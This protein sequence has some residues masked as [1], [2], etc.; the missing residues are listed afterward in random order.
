MTAC[1]VCK[2]LQHQFKNYDA[3]TP[4]AS[5]RERLRR[6]LRGLLRALPA[7]T[8]L[9]GT[10]AGQAGSPFGG[11]VRVC[12]ECGHAVMETPPD[13]AGLKRYYGRQYWS[14]RPT[15]D[16]HGAQRGQTRATAQVE[17][18]RECRRLAGQPDLPSETLEIGAA[19]AGATLRFKE[20][21]G[22]SVRTSVC[23]PGEHW[24]GHYAQHNIERLAE[25]YPFEA[26][27]QFDHIHSSHWLEHVLDLESTR[28]ALASQLKPGG[29]LFM[30]VPNCGAP[31]WELNLSDNPH[32]HFFTAASL[33]RAF[34]DLGLSCLHC[35]EY[36]MSLQERAAGVRPAAEQHAANPGGIW[37]RAVFLNPA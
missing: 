29:T 14:E 36:G 5:T 25:Y 22:D 9:P 8:P 33:R 26:T 10:L 30:E 7:G 24:S 4:P 1:P 21:S 15:Q 34:S 37:L 13:L 2:Q 19:W 17:L 3:H 16:G 32:I 23:E 27:R 31:Y 18:V 11:R 12:T 20:L 28:R 6:G 35:A